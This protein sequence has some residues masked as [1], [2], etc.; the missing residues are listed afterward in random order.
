[1]KQQLRMLPTRI[2]T[3]EALE[4][5]LS[6]PRED[7]I[8]TLRALEGDIMVLGV[9]GK[10]GPTLAALAKRSVDEAGLGKRVI[11]VSR[12]SAPDLRGELERWGVETIP[13]D[14]L[15]EDSLRAL[16]QV[17]NI[18][19]MAGMK[20]G[21]TGREP[22]TWAMNAYLPGMVARHFRHSRMV[23]FSSGNVYP[24]TPVIHGGCSE[25]TP[26]AP[27]GE[28]AQSV[29]G[30]E[31]VFEHFAGQFNV[32]G[33]L[34]RL[35]YA[36]ELCYGVLLDVARQVWA[37]GPIDLSTGHFNCIWQGDANAYAL[38]ALGLAEV[39]PRILNVTGPETISVRSV[40]LRFGALLGKEPVFVGQESPDALLGNA[41][42]AH[43]LLGYPQVPLGA[44]IE[45][46]AG[47]VRSGGPTLDKPTK[48]QVRDG[49]F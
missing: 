26:P 14:L 47:W 42:L 20:F 21:A 19:Y 32:P 43:R 23:L 48:Y 44:V 17:P 36:V 4:E 2:E 49:R 27:V 29:L 10:M 6:R 25:N 34:F 30:R 1:M 11:G 31:R 7:V 40:A 35:N 8:Q 3:V 15:D 37:G 18:I 41:G 45:W 33:V 46:V 38:C 16:P 22:Q 12:F 24:F 9:G 28:Y 13:C 39:P 5:F